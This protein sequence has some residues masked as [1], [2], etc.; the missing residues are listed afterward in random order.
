VCN[1]WNTL[2]EVTLSPALRGVPRGGAPPRRLAEVEVGEATPRPTGLDEVDRVLSGGL[3]AGSVTLLGGEPGIGKSTLLLQA[4]ASFCR[5]G[6][7][8]LYVAAEESAGQVRARAERLGPLPPGVWVVSE[9]LVDRIPA[10]LD[11]TAPALVVIDSI[12]AMR[13]GEGGAPP[14][15]VTQVRECAHRLVDE[16]KDR[17]VAMVMVGHVTKDGSLA[18]PRQ[19]E[20]LVDTVLSFE[21]DR[22]HALRQLRAVKHRHGATHEL[23]LFEMRESGLVGVSD[24]SGLFLGD[25]LEGVAGSLVYPMVE[26]CR[27]LLVELQALVAA[28]PSTVPRRSVEG[29]D[30][31]RMALLLAVLDK[32]VD[33]PLQGCDVYALAVGGVQAVEPAADLA[34]ALALLSSAVGRPIDPRLVACGEVGLAG[35]LR[36]VPHLPRRLAEA[37]RLGFRRAIVPASAPDAPAGLEVVRVGSVAEAAVAA[38]LLGGAMTA[39]PGVPARAA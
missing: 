26:G 1:N 13:A 19:L 28:T 2:D 36:N 38:G 6:E 22:H 3:V 14:G 20:H 30:A 15:S 11:V 4:V 35:E 37:E 18:G 39:R 8:A 33:V 29:I 10:C 5:H 16:A 17:G 32:R 24:P 27:P 25:R 23:G 21:G 7:A 12:Q 31:G 9:G 34:V